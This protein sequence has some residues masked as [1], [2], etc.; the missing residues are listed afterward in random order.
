M[1]APE[2]QDYSVASATGSSQQILDANPN[3]RERLIV[4]IAETDWWINI[5]G[6]AAVV[7][8]EGSFKLAPG[9]YFNG[10]CTNI[11]NAIGTAASKLTVKEG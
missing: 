8:G 3:V 10:A 2:L 9:G 5:S 6:E 11:V 1:P 7:D 4:N